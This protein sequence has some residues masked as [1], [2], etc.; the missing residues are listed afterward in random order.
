VG[1]TV[2]SGTYRLKDYLN[3]KKLLGIRRI[4]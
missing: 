1:L 2:V 3:G 4:V